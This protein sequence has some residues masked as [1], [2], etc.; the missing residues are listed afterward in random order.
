MVTRPV[1]IVGPLADVVL[2][3]IIS[4]YPH[5]FARCEPEFMNCN[6]EALEKGI[7]NN[8]LVDFRR[9]GSHYE[10]TT[11]SAIKDICDRVSCSLLS[12]LCF[13]LLPHSWQGC[14]G[15]TPFLKHL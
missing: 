4:D 14:Y 10:C 5:Q 13:V 2:D 15:F 12:C 11:V 6:Q 1:L 9:R 3:K 7:M 8:I